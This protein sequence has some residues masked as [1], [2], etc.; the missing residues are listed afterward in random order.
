MRPGKLLNLMTHIW[1]KNPERIFELEFMLDRYI[2]NF[3]DEPAREETWK[4]M[5]EEYG[6]VTNSKLKLT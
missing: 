3:M 4:D 5:E 2:Q 1:A 6:V